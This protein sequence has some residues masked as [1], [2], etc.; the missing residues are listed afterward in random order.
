MS[1]K[2]ITAKIFDSPLNTLESKKAN[3]FQKMISRIAIA[4]LNLIS[5]GGYTVYTH[6]YFE[7]RVIRHI[8]PELKES[9]KKNDLTHVEDLFKKFPAL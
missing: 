8:L 2:A 4:I 6:R 3:P 1:V 9:I 5:F 7:K